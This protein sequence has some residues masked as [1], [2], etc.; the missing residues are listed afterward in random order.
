MARKKKSGSSIQGTTT[1][2]KL[3]PNFFSGDA[4]LMATVLIFIILR[5][6]YMPY[7]P[8]VYFLN[9]KYFHSLLFLQVILAEVCFGKQP[10]V[11]LAKLLAVTIAD[12]DF[13]L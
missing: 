4:K 10:K 2:K 12:N 13:S 8:Q 9:V 11:D 5:N 7:V 1:P 3:N 6:V